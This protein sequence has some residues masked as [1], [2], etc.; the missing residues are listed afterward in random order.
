[1]K[2]THPLFI[3]CCGIRTEPLKVRG[4]IVTL[5][6][7]KF[8]KIA[9]S[10]LMPPFLMNIVSSSDLWMFI[11]STSALTAGRRNPDCAL[12][13]YV[14]DDQIHDSQETTG[15]K[16][17]AFVS[18]EQKSH[19]WEPF[20][21]HYWG[22]YRTER[23]IYKNTIGNQII[24]E[25]VNHDLKVNFQCS[26]L[27]S[28]RFG[29]IKKTQFRN[30]DSKPIKIS[31]L[32]GIQNLLPA[33]VNRKLQLEYST[34]VDG[35]KKNELQPDTGLALY[36]LSSIPTDRAEPSESLR[37]T[38]V[39]SVGLDHPIVLL[40]AAQMDAFRRGQ[41]VVQETDVH[42][43][44]GAYFLVSEFELSAGGEREWYLLADVDKDQSEIVA[45]ERFLAAD[46][47]TKQRSIEEQVAKN[48]K[49]LQRRLARADGFQLTGDSLNDLRHCSNT[50]FNI[51][52]GG[53]FEDGYWIQSSDFCSFVEQANKPLAVA[54]QK[55]L[56]GLPERLL[57][58]E[59][60]ERLLPVDPDLEKLCYE[61]LPLAF[62]RRHGDPSRPWNQFSIDIIDE[63]GNKKL[64]YEGNWRDIFQNWEALALSFP[65]YIE[66]MLTKFVNA[67]T[68]DGYNPYRVTRDGFDWEVPNP[69]ESWANIGYWGDHQIIYLL[70]LL[71][72]SV[73]H[74][75]GKINRLLTREI[76]AYANIP[77][78]IKSYSAIL[79]NPRETIDFDF[80]LDRE[81]R[82]RVS[83][84][85]SDGKFI[86][87]EKNRIFHVNLT[88]KLLVLILAKF[89][90]FIPEAGIWMNTQRPEWN[91][92]NNALVGYGA[93]MVTLSYLR[94]FL[95]FCLQLFKELDVKEIQVTEQVFQFFKQIKEGLERFQELLSEPFT[96]R[97]RKRF[98]DQVGQAGS[99]HRMNIYENGFGVRRKHL[100]TDDLLSF[101]QIG[102]RYIDHSLQANKRQDNFYHSYNL[103]QMTVKEG[104]SIRHM[105]EM[106]EGQVALL[107][108]G[109]LTFGDAAMLV[110]SL[111]ASDLY[112]QDQSSYL[113][114][115]DRRLS[116][117]MDKNII[118]RELLNRSALL[119]TFLQQREK[120]IVKEDDLGQ[121]HFNSQFRNAQVLEQALD[122]LKT[123]HPDVSPDE[124]RTILDI[125]ETIFD[126][127]SFTGRSGTFYKY[128]GLGSIYWHMVSKLL[129]A[130]Q[131]TFFRAVDAH[132]HPDV[133]R[134]LQK[135]YYE[136]REGLGS[137]KSPELVGAFPTDP[138]SHTPKNAG[139]QQPGMTGQ[140]KED[141]IARFGEL[142]VRV[143]DGEI[144]FEPRLLRDDEWLNKPQVFHY[145]DVNN[146]QQSIELEKGMLAFTLCQVP[147]VY[148]QSSEQKVIVF[149]R[150]GQEKEMQGLRID[151]G[152]SRSIFQ[153]Q[154]EI[155]RIQ[156]QVSQVFINRNFSQ[157][158]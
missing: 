124:I 18:K 123:R 104:I 70:K 46:R 142:G 2:T 81:I 144:R 130:V 141:I 7:E 9:N 59:L 42:G 96:S 33:G 36:T 99:D 113:L 68:A 135:A 53:I 120:T 40:S 134:E 29:L 110:S 138:Y 71:E 98:L 83:E 94:R 13:P 22:V 26:W 1:M 154:G 58:Q 55:V 91:D 66:N 64:N 90:N 61:Y 136:I 148:R 108:S 106:L 87:D 11:S 15:S 75:P 152:L 158:F 67:C 153:R 19:L 145:F 116:R 45:L 43:K 41:A 84:M 5:Q 126:H 82:K 25:E 47:T 115:P 24:F 85:G 119:Q 69:S 51:M 128:E 56:S 127:Q 114:Y 105:V 137:H 125:Y 23:N 88:E 63:H 77:Y 149:T 97:D 54:N 17:I 131:D 8:Y 157:S 76:F 62:G 86:L 28:D 72:L 73:H 118:P 57:I 95:E 74:H 147:I 150:E 117:F 151:A 92:A 27:N 93:S 78:K 112:R 60:I 6:N 155:E 122:E 21:R 107:S 109:Y 146:Q 12:F 32:D 79:Q 31:I 111:P 80:A 52:R 156:V 35:Y 102:I 65:E 140:V 10:D 48:S 121:V 14:T 103:I 44:R 30:D 38:T 101:F 3:G 49:D 50:L 129:L 132:A 100:K 39:W 16:T 133:L 34:L 139:A 4:E 143:H 37:A 20:S 89:S